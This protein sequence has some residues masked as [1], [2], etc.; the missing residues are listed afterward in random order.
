MTE[1]TVA[2]KSFTVE[3]DYIK[4]GTFATDMST[5]ETKQISSNGYISRDI[6]VRKAIAAAFRLPTFKAQAPRK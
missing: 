6:T 3:A 1:N 4:R 2:G 5:G